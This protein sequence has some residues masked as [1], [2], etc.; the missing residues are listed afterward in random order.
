MTRGVREVRSGLALAYLQ[1]E[2]RALDGGV[3]VVV[4]YV[5]G[6][7]QGTQKIVNVGKWDRGQCSN[8]E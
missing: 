3:I 7:G 5:L 2:M 4:C 6:L 8:L 1:E